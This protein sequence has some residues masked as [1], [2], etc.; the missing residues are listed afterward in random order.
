M[1]KPTTTYQNFRD[2]T[3]DW[4]A[5]MLDY[6]ITSIDTKSGTL[7]TSN[8]FGNSLS[9]YGTGKA[10]VILAGAWTAT[11]SLQVSLSTASSPATWYNLSTYGAN[12]V[13]AIDLGVACS[14]RVGIETGNYTSGTVNWFTKTGG[15]S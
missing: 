2:R 6:N 1:A 5:S 9:I 14:L 11:V 3:Y 7:A 13:T 8:S 10:L 4:L 15:R 12:M